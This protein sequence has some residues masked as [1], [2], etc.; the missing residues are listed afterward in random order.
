MKK[1]KLWIL[2]AGIVIIASLAFAAFSNQGTAVSVTDAKR[3]D[4]KKY[5]EDIGT[6]KCKELR[7]VSIEGSGLI[8][9]V[10]AEVGQQVKKGDLLLSIE[11]DQLE[12]QL[13]NLD[14]KIKEIKASFESSDVKNYASRVEQARIA[15]D[16]SKDVYGTALE[17][18]NKVKS[19]AVAG[20]ASKTELTQKEE[21]LRS[22]EALM[23]TARLDLQQIEANTPDSVE[24]V[25]K[26][27]L[28]QVVLSRESVL[29]SLEKQ[30]VVSPMDGV[31]LERHAEVN[32]VGVSGTVAF[33]IG[34]LSRLEI[35]ADILADEVSNIKVGD[36]VEITERSE[37]KHTIGGKVVK[38][39]PGAIAVTSSLGVNQKRVTIT[40]E[41][42]GR[43]ELLRPGYEADVKVIT[44][45]KNSVILTP[46]SSVFDYN[47]KDCVFTVSD[48]KT[49]LR[50]VK[51]G[52]QDEEH[53]EIIEGLK[54]GEPVLT[55][56]DINIKDGMR[57][58]PEK[59]VEQE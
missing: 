31:V 36:E 46:V 4:I 42:A 30:Q 3:G 13:K 14:E 25:Y 17:D 50:V 53:V 54:E 7:T 16:R 35:E 5:V 32:T 23:K 56:P 41:P 49:V 20:A 34:D 26:A 19:L 18:F 48:G 22:A 10:A 1:K 8:Q 51:K 57:I 15:V 27:Q 58:K 59:S 29:H 28:E 45:N 2:A 47:G 33:V 24:A 37:Q 21:A 39:A 11:R 43:S 52:I 12:I 55:A 9:S 38:I 40:I 6:V 44:E